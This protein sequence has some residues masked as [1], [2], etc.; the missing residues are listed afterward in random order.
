MIL[1]AG[2]TPHNIVLGRK[3]QTRRCWKTHRVRE[4]S[5]HWAQ[6]GYKKETRFAK[7]E[8]LK[9]WEQN[10]LDISDEDVRREGFTHKD[11]FINAYYSQYPNA[12]ADVERGE[13]KHVV[14]DFRVVDIFCEP[15]KW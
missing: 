12:D 1:F 13:R 3:T 10:P 6:T 14:I 2:N 8:I 5:F 15:P 7:L 4:G 9:V 11:D